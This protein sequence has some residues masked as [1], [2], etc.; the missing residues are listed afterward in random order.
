MKAIGKRLAACLLACA[1]AASGASCG[2]PQQ[3]EQ[4]IAS[5]PALSEPRETHVIETEHAYAS[6]GDLIVSSVQ[7]A[8]GEVIGKGETDLPAP[9][10]DPEEF[11]FLCGRTVRVRVEEGLK[12]TQPGQVVGYWEYGGAMPDGRFF[13]Y[14]DQPV[15][16]V[17]DKVLLFLAPST[18]S[19]YIPVPLFPSPIAAGADGTV[20][21][22]GELF[23]T[24]DADS[25]QQERAFLELPAADAYGV[26]QPDRCVTLAEYVELVREA[27]P[28]KERQLGQRME[29]RDLPVETNPIRAQLA[30]G[31]AA[32]GGETACAALDLYG[33]AFLPVE[34]ARRLFSFTLREEE[35]P[36]EPET[37]LI[38]W[39]EE[40][41]AGSCARFDSP[42][43]QQ[44][45]GVPCLAVFPDLPA[46]VQGEVLS[47]R[48]DGETVELE[49]HPALPAAR[50]PEALRSCLEED[51]FAELEGQDAWARG[52]GEGD[53]VRI[54]YAEEGQRV[55]L[56]LRP[57]TPQGS[58]VPA[59]IRSLRA[60]EQLPI[61]TP[62]GDTGAQAYRLNGELCLAAGD[63]YELFGLF[64][65]YD[66]EAGV[67]RIGVP[68]RLETNALLPDGARLPNV[69]QVLGLEDAPAS[70]A[71]A[72]GCLTLRYDTPSGTSSDPSSGTSLDDALE[73][74]QR[75]APSLGCEP[76]G[77][78]AFDSLAARTP[79]FASGEAAHTFL[80]PDG[81]ALQLQEDP[82]PEGKAAPGLIVR[83]AWGEGEED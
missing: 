68:D 64:A 52:G 57:R 10:Y 81:T 70:L 25:P 48:T 76:V 16:E 82:Q 61:V 69:P 51:G 65:A 56:F 38:S 8:Y 32:A 62:C 75:W 73:S 23:L 66:R 80:F 35:R 12:N 2:P 60:L 27:V 83:L 74:L 22:P 78:D 79:E 19:P 26:S 1:A 15:A 44:R 5:A 50:V 30:P 67:V 24:A 49:L 53:T 45:Y 39:T 46:A 72:D 71:F 59:A 18:E 47:L 6:L 54:E 17:G 31:L 36:E 63:L 9:S 3:P 28:E 20:F 4:E 11:G 41:T 7:I 58:G 55:R 13:E 42:G 29:A 40:E 33:T 34:E 37:G 21:L 14:P 77:A 43:W